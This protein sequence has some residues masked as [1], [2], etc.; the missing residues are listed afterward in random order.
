M[1]KEEIKK[2]ILLDKNANLIDIIEIAGNSYAK[3]LRVNAESK[4]NL[5]LEY[6]YYKISENTIHDLTKEELERVKG[7]F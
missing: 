4:N 5:G 2:K 6:K 3:A 7:F 1:N